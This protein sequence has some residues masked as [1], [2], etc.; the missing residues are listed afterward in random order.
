MVLLFVEV[1]PLPPWYSYHYEDFSV[2]AFLAAGQLT[3]YPLFHDPVSRIPWIGY[4]SGPPKGGN[5]S[6]R[7]S[8]IL[9][10]GI[11]SRNGPGRMER[12]IA[13]LRRVS[14]HTYDTVY[15]LVFT[16]ERVLALI[17]WHPGDAPNRFGMTEMLIGG[18]FAKLKERAA[19]VGLIEERRALHE[20]KRLD[21]VQ[22]FIVSTSR[23]PI[24]QSPLL[25]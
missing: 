23:S 5:E 11:L 13:S 9:P 7:G 17:A 2:K 18:Q 21:E 6:A 12:K 1:I 15:D 10:C 25:R 16:T 22:G 8:A 4:G 14:G 3:H 24:N 20:E 19:K